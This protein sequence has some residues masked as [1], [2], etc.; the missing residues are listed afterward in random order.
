[1]LDLESLITILEACKKNKIAELVV[2]KDAVEI[3]TVA[4]AG[5]VAPI[6]AAPQISFPVVEEEV[7]EDVAAPAETPAAPIA[8]NLIEL[9]APTPGV[10]YVYPGTTIDKEPLPKEGDIIEAGQVIGLVEA[11][12][13]FNEVTSPKKGKIVKIKVENE[14]LVKIGDVLFEIEP[15]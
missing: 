3:R 9:T 6:A 1:M 5:G 2:R 8:S 12:K 10:A 4:P 7:A 15:L 14:S 11:M 13:M